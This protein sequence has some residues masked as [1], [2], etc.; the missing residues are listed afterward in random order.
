MARKFKLVLRKMNPEKVDSAISS[1]YGVWLSVAAVL[2]IEFARTISLALTIVDSF[3][4]PINKYVVPLICKLTPSEYQRWVPIV[5]H[6][7]IKSIA[8]SFAFY[9]Q[10]IV[11][12]TASALSGGLLMSQSIYHFC[13]ERNFTLFGLLKPSHT[14]TYIDEIFSYVFAGLGFYTQIKA[15]FD[16]RFPLNLLLWPFEL[17][18]YWIRWTITRRV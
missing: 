10:S 12:A 7:I 2:S 6:W 14:E 8:M 1:I 16:V 3:E 5:I 17:L 4:K 13:L 15:G 18:E 9:I 11:S